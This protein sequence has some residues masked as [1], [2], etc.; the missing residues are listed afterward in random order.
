MGVL[1]NFANALIKEFINIWNHG[2]ALVT[3]FSPLDKAPYSPKHIYSDPCAKPSSFRAETG[4]AVFKSEEHGWL[5]HCGLTL[6]LKCDA[7][8][9]DWLIC[10]QRLVPHGALRAPSL[11][12][13]SSVG[14]GLHKHAGPPLLCSP[15]NPCSGSQRTRDLEHA[16]WNAVKILHHLPG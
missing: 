11:P 15:A 6:L 2:W 4:E 1:W 14:G 5:F 16:F 3:I 7:W 12:F 10:P 9:N 13:R 8:C